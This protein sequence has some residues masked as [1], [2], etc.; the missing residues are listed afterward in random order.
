MAKLKEKVSVRV[1]ELRLQEQAD[2]AN[3]RG[4]VAQA[5]AYEHAISI[6]VEEAKR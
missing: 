4:N 2:N 1:L 6:L 5:K 3:A